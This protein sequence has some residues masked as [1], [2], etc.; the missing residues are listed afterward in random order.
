MRLAYRSALDAAKERG[1]RSVALCAVSTG[2]Y[3]YKVE[4]ATPVAL[5]A[6][7]EWLDE[8]GE[9]A[10]AFDALLFCVFSERDLAVYQRYLPFHFPDGGG[11]AL[12]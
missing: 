2:I 12:E 4:A 10:A 11:G 5:A 7:R 3:G 9:Q 1:F 8:S 6:V